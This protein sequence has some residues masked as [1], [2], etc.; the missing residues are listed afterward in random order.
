MSERHTGININTRLL[1]VAETWNIDGEHVSAV[2]TD[3]TSNMSVTE[4]APLLNLFSMYL[5]TCC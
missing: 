2:V 3:N 4:D 5:T 1:E